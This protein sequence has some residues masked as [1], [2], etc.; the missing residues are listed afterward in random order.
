MTSR[1]G[2]GRWQHVLEARR[3]SREALGRDP[4]QGDLFDAPP[5]KKSAAYVPLASPQVESR[6][7][8]AVGVLLLG[9]ACARLGLTRAELEALI[10]AGKVE[11]LPMGYSVAIPTREVERLE[12]KRRPA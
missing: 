5:K 6:P 3:Q 10:E 7:S 8:E 4:G 12:A 9:E 2:R 1:S 11:A